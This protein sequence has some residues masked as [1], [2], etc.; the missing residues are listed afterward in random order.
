MPAYNESLTINGVADEIQV[1]VKGH[2][3]QNTAL[4]EWQQNSGATPLARVTGDGKLQVGSVNSL[5]ASENALIQAHRTET[6]TSRPRRGLNVA[7]Y[8]SGALSE[9]ITWVVQELFL[10]GTGG[11]SAALHTA[12]RARLRNE[13]TGNMS[14]GVSLLAADIVAENKGGNAGSRVPSVIGLRVGVST[15]SGGYTDTAYG[16]KVEVNNAGPTNTA[17]ALHTGAGLVHIEDAIEIKGLAVAPA[18]PPAEH[19]RVYGRNGQVYAKNSMGREAIV[20]TFSTQREIDFGPM[21]TRSKTFTISDPDVLSTSQVMA[22]QSGKAAT[23]RSADEN[24]MDA[25]S[26]RC[27]SGDGQFTLYADSLF[28]PVAGRYVIDYRIA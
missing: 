2:T 13:N 24:E 19:L 9:V 10:K 17:Y 11:I 27:V 21:G 7:G 15:E 14:S 5:T 16:I 22:F 26:L 8:L 12:L 20:T 23:G 3:T 25:L 28:G 4:Q 18:K 1:R 6:D